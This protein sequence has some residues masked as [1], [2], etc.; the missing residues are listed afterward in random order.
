MCFVE[1][2]RVLLQHAEGVQV[3]GHAT[4]VTSA[5]RAV[6][7]TR[8]DLLI[9]D[10]SLPPWSGLD[11]LRALSAADL[12]V[13][14]LMITAGA[15]EDDVAEAIE[16]GARGVVLKH[17]TPDLL[18]RAIRAVMAGQYW[19]G[20][21]QVA[22]MIRQLR[23]GDEPAPPADDEGAPLLFTERQRQIMSAIVSG[24]SNRGIAEELSIRPTTVKYHLSQLFEKTGT[25][26]R[27]ALARMITMRGLHRPPRQK[28]RA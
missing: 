27:V 19:I 5:I 2:L 20:R 12:S 8:P 6:R 1:S 9:L 11:V 28:R 16:L 18:V 15:S 25:T 23:G 13:P 10:F 22:G 17:C 3:V 24:S 26:N 4:D 7:E 21:D 14:A